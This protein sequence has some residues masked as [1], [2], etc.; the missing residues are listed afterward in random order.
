MHKEE[1]PPTKPAESAPKVRGDRYPGKPTKEADPRGESRGRTSS[2]HQRP[3]TV[4]SVRGE[5]TVSS[6]G[7]QTVDKG[8]SLSERR[9]VWFE[10]V[11]DLM[12]D[13]DLKL[14]RS[15][16]DHLSAFMK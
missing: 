14:E 16:K 15:A 9:V 2:N 6:W 12:R 7:S 4:S 3:A 8:A 11:R 5:A 13:V 1:A 10:L